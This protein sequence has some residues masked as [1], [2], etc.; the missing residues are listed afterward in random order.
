MIRD[1]VG[2]GSDVEMED[3]GS[4]KNMTSTSPSTG[5]SGD[6][7]GSTAGATTTTS[8][9]PRVWKRVDVRDEAC[10]V[11]HVL[12]KAHRLCLRKNRW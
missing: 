3:V 11:M 6:G 12:L 5:T 4:G 8:S 1:S 9:P 7:T 10:I 2:D